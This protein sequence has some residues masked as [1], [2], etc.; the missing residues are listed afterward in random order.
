[1]TVFIPFVNIMLLYYETF[2]MVEAFLYRRKK[3]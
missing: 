1:M 2:W 3:I